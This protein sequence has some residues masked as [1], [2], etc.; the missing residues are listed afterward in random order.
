MAPTDLR[1]SNAR[2]L[3]LLPFILLITATA[4]MALGWVFR[5]DPDIC[6][7][8]QRCIGHCPTGALTMVGPNAY[9]D[10]ELCDGCGDCVPHCIRGAIFKDWYEGIE[11]TETNAILS[12]APN[13]STGTFILT[14][15]RQGSSISV[16]DVSGHEVWA[17][18]AGAEGTLQIVMEG[19]PPG[20]YTV[21]SEGSL[22]LTVTIAGQRI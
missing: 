5:V 19:N 13:P 3:R 21:L 8:C 6:N 4:L 14:G 17:G 1:N 15:V 22:P 12:A 16:F 20:A 2:S 10:P 7:G 18:T 9:I 11:E